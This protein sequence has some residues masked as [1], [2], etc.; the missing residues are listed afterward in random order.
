[1][2]EFSSV[3]LIELSNSVVTSFELLR[4]IFV[5]RFSVLETKIKFSVKYVSSLVENTMTKQ[6]SLLLWTFGELFPN[7]ALITM[8]TK[9]DFE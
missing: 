4:T 7:K 3:E 9:A 6:L 2:S 8:T 1:M 5:L